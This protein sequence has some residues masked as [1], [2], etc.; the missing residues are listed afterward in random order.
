MTLGNIAEAYAKSTEAIAWLTG[1]KPTFSPEAKHRAMARILIAD[2]DELIAE[3]ASEVLFN[4][5]HACGWVTSA[6]A[7]WELASHKRPDILLL[8]QIMPGMS[9][10]TLLRRL[11]GSEKFYDLPVVMFTAMSGNEDEAQAFYAGAQGYIRKPF[12]PKVLVETVTELLNK[13]GDRPRHVDLKQ[14]MAIESGLISEP[15][16]PL[17]RLL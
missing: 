7:A 13:R 6:E 1:H 9:G 11:R 2:D 15:G 14:A 16:E 4:A 3:I 5:G 17:R 12:A 8:D 10:V